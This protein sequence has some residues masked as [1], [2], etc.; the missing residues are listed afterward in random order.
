[1]RCWWRD[2]S[3]HC[4]VQ[5]LIRKASPVYYLRHRVGHQADTAA[6]FVAVQHFLDAEPA[7]SYV[8]CQKLDVLALQEGKAIEHL[9]LIAIFKALLISFE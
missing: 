1:M 2:L 9:E 5:E 4:L 8:G 6:I 7:L 3:V